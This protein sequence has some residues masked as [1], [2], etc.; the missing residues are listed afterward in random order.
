[1]SEQSNKRSNRILVIGGGFSGLTTAVDA[2]ETGA[3]VIVIEKNPYFG[4]RVAQLNKY[5]PKLCPP[6]CGLELNFK[7]IRT[8]PLVTLYTMAEVE[9]IAGG[10]GDYSV[11]VK[12]HPRYVNDNCTAC[13]ACA[14]ACPAERANEYNFGMNRTKAAYLPFNQAF[15]QKYVIDSA[16]CTGDCGKACKEACK[17]GAVDLEMKA[18]TLNL[19]VDSVV[20]ATGWNPYDPNKLDILGFGKVKNVITNMMMERLA[21][22]TGPTAG[23]ILR[24]SDGKPVMNI[25]FVQCAG[26]RDENHLPYC[27]YICCLASL[28]Q[29]TYIREQNPGSKARIF[30]IDIRTPG[31]YE[32]FYGKVKDDPNV[33][34]TK[35]KVAHIVQAEGSDDVIV[36]AEDMLT[37]AKVK[38]QADMVVLATGMEP[39]GT[40]RKVSGVSYNGDGFVLSAQGINAA[41]C[42]KNPMDVARSAQ[43]STSAVL[44]AIKTG[45]GR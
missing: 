16:S 39:S 34:F 42:S 25:V 21:S 7:R 20:V 15:P 43:D 40:S 17:Y 12:L 30:Y 8:N 44:K 28:K 29:V 11:T 2:A 41:G 24:P 1:M 19:K 23:K 35:G 36:E 26:S 4:G 6:L 31:K 32:K 14:E 9:N 18:E 13:N 33:S 10:P 45:Q 22:P 27:S 5:F 3:E 38:V 37:G